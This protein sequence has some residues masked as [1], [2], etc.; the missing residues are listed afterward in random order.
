MDSCGRASSA[1][2]RND[3]LIEGGDR[4]EHDSGHRATVSA[5][6]LE[7]RALGLG[8]KRPAAAPLEVEGD[9]YA[10]VFSFTPGNPS[11]AIR[12]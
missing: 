3:D 10:A 8:A 1:P 9:R 6:A 12:G 11:F 2:N 7:H 5:Q 4:T